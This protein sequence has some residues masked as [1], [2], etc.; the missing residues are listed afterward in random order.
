M[1]GAQRQ[2]GNGV[3]Q[4]DY[5]FLYVWFL[6]PR[7]LCFRN[8]GQENVPYNAKVFPLCML[9]YLR[10][11][12]LNYF[13]THCHDFFAARQQCGR[14]RRAFAGG[15][16]RRHN[17]FHN[18]CCIRVQLVLDRFDQ[19][20]EDQAD[21]RASRTT[22]CSDTV[23]AEPSP[24][25]FAAKMPSSPRQRTERALFYSLTAQNTVF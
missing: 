22:E 25:A 19:F 9:A 23:S 5:V 4:I 10:Q 8:F 21:P 12:C 2:Q 3:A 18:V 1:S 16:Y 15:A 6:F 20:K 24:S 7:R 17:R 13:K 11:R 14:G